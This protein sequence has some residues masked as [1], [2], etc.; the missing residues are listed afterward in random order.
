MPREDTERAGGID[1]KVT[2]LDKIFFPEDG[3]TKGDLIR[4]SR[5][6][7][8]AMIPYLRDRPLVMERYPDGITGQGVVQKNVPSY[9]PEW[10]SRA[11]VPKQHGGA[12]CQ[13]VGDKPPT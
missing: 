12:L 11:E 10:V 13:V 5:S 7:A 6:V 1:V 4:Y 3:I 9:F 2:R 8:A